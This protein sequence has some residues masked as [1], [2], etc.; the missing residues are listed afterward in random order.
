MKYINSNGDAGKIRKKTQ[1]TQA[2]TKKVRERWSDRKGRG[3]VGA[4]KEREREMEG[5]RW[6]ERQRENGKLF[7]LASQKEKCMGLP[8]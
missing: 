3:D 1:T 8:R 6:R 5:G 2:K 7:P 4:K